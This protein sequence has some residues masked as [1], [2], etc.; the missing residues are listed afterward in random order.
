MARVVIFQPKTDNFSRG[1][2]KKRVSALVRAV[3]MDARRRLLRYTGNTVEPAPTGAHARSIRSSVST[4]GRWTIKGSVGS[5]LPT[6]MVVHIGARPHTIRPRT[7][8]GM[9]FY[10]KAKGRFVCI[11]AP[12]FHPGMHGKFYLTEPLKV[13]GRRLGFRVVLAAYTERLYR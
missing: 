12:V 11:K 2:A 5:N 10:W 6:A 9:K 13:E 1:F 8:P 4:Q 7:K 3:D